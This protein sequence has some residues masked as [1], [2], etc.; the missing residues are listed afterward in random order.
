M[1]PLPD[2]PRFVRDALYV[3]VGFGLLGVNQF[4]VRRRQLHA[5]L[6]RLRGSGASPPGSTTPARTPEGEA[7]SGGSDPG[8]R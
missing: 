8:A 7:P 5:D 1:A 6:Q 4:Q 2:V 3:G